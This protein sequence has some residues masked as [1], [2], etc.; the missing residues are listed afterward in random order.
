MNA[1]Q[2]KNRRSELWVSVSELYGKTGR[3]DLTRLDKRSVDVLQAQLTAPKYDYSPS[4]LRMVVEP[5]DKTKK[6]IGRSPDD[7]D[8][9]NLAYYGSERV[10]SAG[11]LS[12]GGLKKQSAWTGGV[13]TGSRWS[14]GTG[15]GGRNWRP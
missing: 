5:K 15:R 8:A 10:Y 12:S 14:T 4:D 13:E 1:E 11:E 7:A 6:R 3:L 2:F 9:F